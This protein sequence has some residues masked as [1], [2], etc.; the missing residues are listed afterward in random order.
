MQDPD[1]KWRFFGILLHFGIFAKKTNKKSNPI[2]SNF[3]RLL[4][5]SRLLDFPIPQL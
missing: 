1:L 5:F 3:F 4:D 2:L